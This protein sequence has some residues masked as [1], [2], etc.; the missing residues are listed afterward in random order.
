MNQKTKTKIFGLTFITLFAFTTS[1]SE[2]NSNLRLEED[3]C[4]SGRSVTCYGSKCKTG[5]S[6]CI[7]NPCNCPPPN[8]Q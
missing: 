5:D 3:N 6:M 2:N 1:W 7:P 8:Q 4:T